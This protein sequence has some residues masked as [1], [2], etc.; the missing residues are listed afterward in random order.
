MKRLR[1]LLIGGVFDDAG[2]RPSKL[3]AKLADNLLTALY[4]ELN[5]VSGSWAID[6]INGGSYSMLSGLVD[7]QVTAQY[8]AVLWFADV[9]ND[10]RK[11]VNHV[12][13]P[14]GVLII[15]KNNSSNKYTR[16]DL[17]ER[18]R[19]S[20]ALA[21]VEFRR[22]ENGS[23]YEHIL[24]TTDGASNFQIGTDIPRLAYCLGNELVVTCT[25]IVSPIRTP[26][27][28]QCHNAPGGFGYVRK[29]HVHE[30]VDI[31]VPEETPVFNMCGGTIA[32]IGRFTG[33]HVGSPWW[34]DTWCVMVD[35][36]VGTFNYGEIRP[37]GKLSIGEPIL[38]GS[39]IGT[40]L[41]VLRNDKG[42]P[43]SML[44]LELYSRWCKQTM[45]IHEWPLHAERPR[46]LGNVTPILNIFTL[47]VSNG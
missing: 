19:V 44:H 43:T 9:P 18:M 13:R 15:S 25:Q 2:G 11:L 21:L 23:L 24:H 28:L 34:N 40:V 45:P 27:V 3:I 33:P 35:T 8:D 20:E 42:K 38:P 12:A 30:G 6:V 1:I 39:K 17:L 47:V 41:R 10:K 31:Y 37:N 29:H 36:P 32:H 7:T 14:G 22:Q 26:F 16:N 46:G 4:D 5:V